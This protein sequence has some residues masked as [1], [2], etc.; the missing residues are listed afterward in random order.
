M[1]A[2]IDYISN[3]HEAKLI[4]KDSTPLSIVVYGAIKNYKDMAEQNDA[5]N[6]FLSEAF[7]INTLLNTYG[8]KIDE[9]TKFVNQL[10]LYCKYI[11]DAPEHA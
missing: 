2:L 9:I 6:A 1:D 7:L 10:M 3:T 8:W 5:L 4:K 11:I